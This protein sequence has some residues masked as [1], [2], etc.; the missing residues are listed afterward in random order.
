MAF[1]KE[2]IAEQTA[3]GNIEAWYAEYEA[4]AASLGV[5]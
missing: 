4:L 2:V 3:N 1:V 5:S